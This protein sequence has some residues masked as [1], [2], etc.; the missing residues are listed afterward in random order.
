MN[1]MMGISVESKQVTVAKKYRQVLNQK[2]IP[3]PDNFF[4]GRYTLSHHPTPSLEV[5]VN[6]Y[7]F[8]TYRKQAQNHQKQEA[9]VR[10]N[11]WPR[12]Y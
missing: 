4:S 8:S 3:V 10:S 5:R 12:N 1:A 7:S 9:Q 2:K 11:S 6:I